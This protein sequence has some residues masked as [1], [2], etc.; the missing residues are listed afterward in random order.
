YLIFTLDVKKHSKIIEVLINKVKPKVILQNITTPLKKW[1]DIQP[2]LYVGFD[3]KIGSLK[4]ANH[5]ISKTGKK[6]NYAVLYGTQGYVSKM[7]GDSVIRH[8][9]QKTDLKMVASYYTDFNKQ[10]AYNATLDLLKENKDL[11]FIYACSTDI[12]HGAIE[13]LKELGLKDKILV[14]GWGGGGSELKAILK[15]D[16]DTTVIRINDDNGVAMAEA[17]KLDLE[18]KK[19]S[20]PLIYSGDMRLIEKGI[21]KSKIDHIRKKAFRYSD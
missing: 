12:A 10:K 18:G 16:M 8:F 7:R 9:N 6:G 15:G 20:V 1:G 17:I 2:F 14:N 19:K 13:A 11:K 21:S 5:F 3:H 4:I